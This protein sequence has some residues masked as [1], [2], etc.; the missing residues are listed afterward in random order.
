M[1]KFNVTKK[2]AVEIVNG[3]HDDW[4]VVEVTPVE[5]ERWSVLYAVI[6]RHKPT[7]KFYSDSFRVAATEEQDEGP[8][9][10]WGPNFTEV[11]PYEKTITAYRPVKD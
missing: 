11:E 8:Y 2:E 5:Q 3:D 6:L 10:S 9:D 7:G 4:L 1:S